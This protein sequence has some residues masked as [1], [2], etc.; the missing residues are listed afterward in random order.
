MKKIEKEFLEDYSNSIK[1][2]ENFNDIKN[3]IDF[4]KY[5]KS[6]NNQFNARKLA[7]LASS[8]ATFLVV[9]ITIPITI[10]TSHT[11]HLLRLTHLRRQQQVAH[12]G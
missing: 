8:L 4:N 5:K 2:D 3:H 11:T 12:P 1:S 6:K 9:C 7:V 10:N